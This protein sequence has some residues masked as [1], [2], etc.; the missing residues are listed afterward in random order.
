[1]GGV[2]GSLRDDVCQLYQAGTVG[3]LTMMPLVDAEACS[4]S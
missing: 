4:G 2:E 3:R 1:M